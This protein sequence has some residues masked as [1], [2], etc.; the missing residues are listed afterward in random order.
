MFKKLTGLFTGLSTKKTAKRNG[1]IENPA[2]S[3]YSD[4]TLDSLSGSSFP[5][6]GAIW[7]A[8]TLISTG[9]A[10][11]PINLYVKSDNG[12]QKVENEQTYLLR[13]QPNNYQNAYYFKMNMTFSAVFCGNAYAWI[14]RD[15]NFKVEEYIQLDSNSTYPVR[16]NGIVSYITNVN[17]K[18]IKFD[19]WEIIHLRGIGDDLIGWSIKELGC[20]AFD[21]S[22]L[23]QRYSRNFFTNSARP[24]VLIEHP[25]TLSEEAAGRLKRQWNLLHQGTDNAHK[26]AV[27]EE[28]M[29]VNP[30]SINAKDAMLIEG[31]QFSVVDIANWFNIPADRLNA[32]INTSYN[33]L[34]QQNQNYLSDTLDPWLIAWEQELYIKVLSEDAKRSNSMYFEFNR[35][36]LLRADLKAQAEYN[37]AALAGAPWETT[38][39]VRRRQNLNDIEGG[40][41]IIYPCNNFCNDDVEESARSAINHVIERMQARVK[42]DTKCTSENIIERHGDIIDKE[43]FTVCRLYR[44]ITGKDITEKIKQQILEVVK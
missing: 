44:D 24:S 9:C 15:S 42:K 1:S 19:S 33:S 20:V 27:L 2:N 13:Y 28:G 12:R 3:L 21:A 35:A 32:N 31:M 11:L 14:K 34:E 6:F 39:E 30:F 36:A 8:C 5:R 26:T 10:K 41:E 37:K 29:K 43:L 17:G 40:D 25:A 23:A 4:E 16:E 7:R 22:V 38:N 18:L